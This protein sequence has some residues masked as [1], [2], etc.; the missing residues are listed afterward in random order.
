MPTT[1]R[2]FSSGLAGAAL[3]TRSPRP[4]NIVLILSDD[5]TVPHLGCYGDPVIQTPHLDRFAA[6]GIRFDRAFT[7][8]PQ[9]VPSRTGFLTG[10]SPVAARM[11]RFSS[12]LPPDI[13]TLPELLRAKEYFTGI[14]RRWYHLD[15]PARPGPVTGPLFEKHAMRTFAKR[16]DFL[17]GG[18]P[19][20]KTAERVNAFF[21]KRPSG[22]PYFL[23][24]N[25][26]DPHHAWDRDNPF[27]R[28]DR[29][30]IP[31][32][33]YLPD[34]PGLRDDL[35]RYYGEISRMD[36]EFRTVLD[37]VDRRGGGDTIVVFA[38]DNGYAF[39]HGKG[40]LYD[41][42]L[43]VPF[44]LRWPGVVK[45]GA[46]TRELVSGED[47]TPTL[48]EAAGV[49]PAKGMTGRSFLPLLR[50][51]AA[52][53]PREHI[54]AARLAHGNSPVTEDTKANTFDLSRCVR[55][56]THKLI[57][58]C[59]PQY[60]YWPVD[61]G[62][63][64]GWQEMA[65]A[66]AGKLAPKHDRAYFGKRPVL[67]LYDL[68]KDPAELDNVAG[69]APYAAIQRELMVALQEKMIVDYDFLPLPL[70]E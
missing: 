14:C 62:R 29:A 58:N 33:A 8:A 23:W 61:S 4:P 70:A 43:N 32:P 17:D 27:D 63:D 35:A 54:F 19:R 57:Y 36:D 44:L 47:L 16:V 60:E 41:P 68:E 48:L 18:S 21:D 55:S 46:V 12:P 65:A 10:R 26:N 42:G 28:Y 51:G 30:R 69:Q 64:A 50:V 1:R 25:F 45:P 24:V 9:C 2:Q 67:E 7:A 37:I 52:Y 40:S 34:L 22:K 49:A 39:P 59:T 11:G 53:Q 56:K 6:Q 15:G 66:R 5:H 13:A 31:V 3:Q 38:G 20:A